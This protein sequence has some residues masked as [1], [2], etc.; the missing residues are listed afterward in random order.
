MGKDIDA[1]KVPELEKILDMH[2]V[3]E[4]G[5]CNRKEKRTKVVELW[6]KPPPLD[7]QWTEADEASLKEFKE[8]KINLKD[9]A[10][11]RHQAQEK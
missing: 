10:L 7:P 2:Q 8:M 11:G 4:K 3:E 9:T 1:L 5:Y 6:S